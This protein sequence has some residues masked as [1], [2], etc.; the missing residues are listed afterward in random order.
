[1]N[2]PRKPLVPGAPQPVGAWRRWFVLGLLGIGA[3]TVVSRAFYLQVMTREFLV[4]EGDKRHIRN[5]RLP[6]LRGAVLDRNGNALAL[7]APVDSLWAV[8]E[9]LLTPAAEPYR[10][11]LAEMLGK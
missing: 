4:T 1:M 5:L 10:A 8:P 2:L 3:M 7:S 11:A 6:G 9:D